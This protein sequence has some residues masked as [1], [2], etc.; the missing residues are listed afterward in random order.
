[1]PYISDSYLQKFVDSFAEMSTKATTHERRIE[2][3]H[4]ASK[5]ISD[6]HRSRELPITWGQAG[7]GGYFKSGE[8]ALKVGGGGR[9]TFQA[10]APSPIMNSELIEVIVKEVIRRIDARERSASPIRRTPDQLVL[11]LCD[12]SETV[13]DCII[14]AQP[15]AAMPVAVRLLECAKAT[16]AAYRKD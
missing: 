7:G 5:L 10:P 4:E 6:V 13:A 1:M 3:A 12:L 11:Y 8:E 16:R 15:G 14:N 2:I 9:S